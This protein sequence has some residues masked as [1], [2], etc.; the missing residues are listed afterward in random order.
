MK[1]QEAK[2]EKKKEKAVV[3]S[4]KVQSDY[5]KEKNSKSLSTVPPAKPKK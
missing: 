3:T 1:G 5:Q 2:K 4:A